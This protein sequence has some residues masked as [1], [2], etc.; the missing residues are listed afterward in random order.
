VFSFPKE[1]IIVVSTNLYCFPEAHKNMKIEEEENPAYQNKSYYVDASHLKAN[2]AR[3]F[4]HDVALFL[5][6]QP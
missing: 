2:G 6:A 4:S 1:I 5:K 3:L